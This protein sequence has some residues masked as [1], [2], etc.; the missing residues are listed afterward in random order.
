MSELRLAIFIVK[1]HFLQVFRIMKEIGLIRVLILIVFALILLSKAIPVLNDNPDYYFLLAFPILFIS[2]YFKG[3][4]EFLE[5]NFRNHRLIRLIRSLILM[6]PLFIILILQTHLIQLLI[7]IS[8]AVLSFVIKTWK[9]SSGNIRIHFGF[10]LLAWKTE[11]RRY[12]PLLILLHLMSLGITHHISVMIIC[13]ILQHIII[14]SFLVN[15]EN[16]QVLESTGL[17]SGSFVNFYVLK[18][19]SY[20]LLLSLPFL[21]ITAV[22]AFEK[23]YLILAILFVLLIHQ[24]LSVL[25]K[26]SFYAPDKNNEEMQLIQW[27][28]FLFLF[29]PFAFLIPLWYLILYYRKAMRNLKIYLILII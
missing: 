22:F 8:L 28:M 21:I 24:L 15:N 17:K 19:I 29:I 3:E 4:I 26:L 27:L 2:F 25:M 13:M 5:I 12:F 9:P 20:F 18:H 6:S 1:L 7:V 16:Q 14:L 11:M 10:K 23:L